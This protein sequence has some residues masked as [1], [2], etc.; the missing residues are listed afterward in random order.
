MRTAD[1][2]RPYPTVFHEDIFHHRNKPEPLPSRGVV[3]DSAGAIRNIMKMRK[4]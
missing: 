2:E 4:K 3:G 1:V